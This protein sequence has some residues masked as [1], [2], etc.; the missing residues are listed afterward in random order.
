MKNDEQKKKNNNNLDRKIG[1]D[2]KREIKQINNKFQFKG[3]FFFVTVSR[4]NFCFC[5][6]LFFFLL[7]S[8]VPNYHIKIKK[9]KLIDHRILSFFVRHWVCKE[10]VFEDAVC[11][12]VYM[13]SG[14]HHSFMFFSSKSTL[15]WLW[16]SGL[17]ELMLI[18]SVVVPLMNVMMIAI[19][20]LCCHWNFVVVAMVAIASVPMKDVNL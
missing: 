13:V 7:I 18:W 19:D 11:V 2:R 10:F 9:K 5:F 20:L 15:S 14:H 17:M 12:C 6:L 16:Y 8:N 4:N 1:K 3:V